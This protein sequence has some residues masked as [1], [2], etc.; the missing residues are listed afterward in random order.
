MRAINLKEAALLVT[1]AAVWG[2]SFLFIRVA[3][4]AMG[5]IL[6]MFLRVTIAGLVL[7]GYAF[8][9]KRLP[10]FKAKWSSYLVLGVLSAALPFTLIAFAELSLPA[11]VAAILNATTPLFSALIAVV[12]INEHLTIRK[13]LGL[14][15]GIV[16]VG[17]LVG[18]GGLTL[19][20]T[21]LIAIGASLLAACLY[22]IGGVYSKAAFQEDAPLSLTIGQQLGASI[23]L[24][25][26]AGLSVPAQAPTFEVGLAVLALSLLCTAFGFVLYFYLIT[27][28]G[29]TRTLSVTFLVP[30]FGL[31]CGTIFL[32]EPLTL[33]WVGG[34]G[35]ILL[36]MWCIIGVPVSQPRRQLTK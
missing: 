20:I 4:P 3:V 11:S 27:K 35:I 9:L 23:V 31:L 34:L 7:L 28:I 25:P 17:V 15:L 16:G 22:A 32:H 5:P 14:L 26:L 33:S 30:V 19:N 29:P 6:L 10:T 13:I 36:S 2:A 24:L 8:I 1:L 21:T 18:G 12:W